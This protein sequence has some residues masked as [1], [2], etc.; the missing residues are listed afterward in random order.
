MGYND[1]M[2]IAL[3][4]L[5]SIITGGLVLVFVEIGNRKNRE[6]DRYDQ[7]MSP[8]MHKLSSYFRFMSWSSSYIIYQKPLNGYEEDFK[9]LVDKMARYGGRATVSGGDYGVEY[10]TADELYQIASEIN[11]IWYY[12]DK[13]HPCRLTWDV[14]MRGTEDFIAKELK[15]IN[16]VFLHANRDVNLV[17]K[18]SGEFYTDLYQYIEYDTFRHEAYQKQYRIQS[19]VVASFFVFVL[20]V[21]GLMTF[22]KIP[23]LLLQCLVLLAILTVLICIPLLAVDVKIQIGWMNRMREYMEKNKLNKDI[24]SKSWKTMKK[25]FRAVLDFILSKM[26]IMGLLL[27][28][29]AIFS[30]EIT[31]IPKIPTNLSEQAATGWNRVF[32]ALAYSY[33]AGVILYAFTV[34]FPSYLQHRKFRPVIKS[35]ITSIGTQLHNMLVPFSSVENPVYLEETDNITAMMKSMDWNSITVIP[36]YPAN[37]TYLRAFHFDCEN[38]HKEIDQIIADYKHLMDAESVLLLEA[39]RTDAVF[40]LVE[41]GIR[42]GGNIS[43]YVRQAIADQFPMVVKKY[44]LL[45]DKYHIDDKMWLHRKK[46]NKEG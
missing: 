29:W 36:L 23:L 19:I 35:K 25:T 13:M 34:N 1:V 12:H 3:T 26:V 37:Y 20:L 40:D 42:A 21:L 6:N 24:F 8:F 38:L 16:P 41:V 28:I 44:L 46:E 9:K 17:A 30:I 4:V 45:A 27:A 11:N 22:L 2:T 39:I 14:R 15:D 33:I 43:E 32:L 10:F 18:V 5:T 31:W 7:I